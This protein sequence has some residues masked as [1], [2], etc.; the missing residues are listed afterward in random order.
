[1]A[2]LPLSETSEALSVVVLS[3]AE[4]Q[5]SEVIVCDISAM[6]R[7]GSLVMTLIVPPMADEP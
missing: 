6:L 1:M 3:K 7:V 4:L 5:P 2:A